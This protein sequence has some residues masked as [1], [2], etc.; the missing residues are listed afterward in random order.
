MATECENLEQINNSASGSRCDRDKVSIPSIPSSTSGG[1]NEQQS[2][3]H[4]SKLRPLAR[5]DR[6]L[7]RWLPGYNY[8]RGCAG[9]GNA[10]AN[11]NSNG[12]V[13]RQL[14]EMGAGRMPLKAME[15]QRV[16]RQR[17]LSIDVPLTARRHRDGEVLLNAGIAK[18]EFCSK[19]DRLLQAKLSDKDR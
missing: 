11:T 9:N 7:R 17:T 1:I 3:T 18:S 5:L 4:V 15:E 10:N 2:S 6:L 12:N 13:G 19:L 14:S 16:E 8:L